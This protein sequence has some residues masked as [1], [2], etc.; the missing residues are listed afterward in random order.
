MPDIETLDRRIA[1]WM[2]AYAPTFLRVSLA[3]V[4]IWFGGL[5]LFGA[6]PANDI[7]A[8][9]VYWFDPGWFIPLLGGWEVAIGVFMLWKPLIRA[10]IA[11]LALQMP[12]TFLPLVLLPEV[13]FTKIPWVPSL[14]G[15]YIIKNLVLI[16]AALAVGGTVRAKPAS[17]TSEGGSSRT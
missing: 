11:L 6:S 1:G 10:S 15:Q 12:G 7:V 3:I 16:A 2:R 5:K 8:R 14:E 17:S 9:T 13:C 4:F